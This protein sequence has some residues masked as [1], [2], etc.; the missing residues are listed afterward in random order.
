MDSSFNNLLKWLNAYK[1]KYYQNLLIKGSILSSALLLSIFLVFNSI[2]Y[3]LRL[4]G[5]LRGVLLFAFIAI[6]VAVIWQWVFTPISRLLNLKKQLSHEEAAI[7]IGKY[8]PQ[9]NDKLLNTIQLSHSNVKD[10]TL[11]QASI[12]QRT[13]ELSVFNFPKAINFKENNQYLKYLAPPVLVGIVILMLIPQLFT[14]GTERIINFNKE[15]VPEAPF[16]FDLENSDLRAFKNEDFN[17]NLGFKGSYEPNEAYIVIGGRK[18]KMPKEG[19]VYTYTFKN[20]QDDAA[21][22]FEAAGFQSADHSIKVLSRPNLKGFNVNLIYPSY[23][24]KDKK[25][26]ENTGNLIIPEG[27]EVQ[28]QFSSQDTEDMKLKFM[29]EDTIYKIKE[30]G[31]QLFSFNKTL[32]NSDEYQVQLSNENSNN[33]EEIKYSIDV[34][35]DQYPEIKVEIFADTTLYNFLVLGGSISDDYGFKALK[36]Y[37][38]IEGEAKSKYSAINLPVNNQQ[39]S[40]SFYF[41]W[42]TDSLLTEPGNRINYFLEVYDN[43]GVNGSKSTKS[44]SYTFKMPTVDEVADKL[45]KEALNTQERISESKNDVE[46][47]KKDLE[48]L[49]N[50]LKGKQNLEWQDKKKIEN[51][52]KRKQEINKAIEELKEK[53]KANNLQRER[54]NEQDESIREKS[55]QL[56]KLMNELLDEETKKLYDELK[57][58]LEEQ[59]DVNSIQEQ[60]SKINNKEQ[61][62]EKELERALELF[63]RMQFDQKLDN[64]VS[65]I[66]ELSKEQEKIAEET[67]EADKKDGSQHEEAKQKQEELN[68]KFEEIKKEID[69]LQEL[70]KDLEH[71]NPIQ[72]T[73][74]EEEKIEEEQQE[75][76]ESLE[77]GKNEKAAKHQE[78][79]AEEMKKLG[80][81]MAQMQ[82]GMEMSMMEENLD[83][84][85][86]ILDNLVKLSFNQEGLMDDFKQ[87]NQSDPRFVKLS[88]HQLKLKDDAKIIEDSLLSLA[89]RVFQIQSF[90]TREVESMNS[91]MEGSLE[92]LKERNPSKAI[93]SQQFAMTSMNNLALL[94]SDVLKQMQQQ[95]ADAMGK[96]QNGKGKG[97]PQSMDLGDLQKQL[98]DKISELKKS[99][100]SGRAMSEELAKLAAQQEQ[101]RRALQ[102]ELKKAENASGEE[103]KGGG[104]SGK[105]IIEKM[106]ETEADLVNKSLTEKTIKRQQD[107]LTRLLESEN[108]IREREEDQERKAEQANDYEQIIPKAFEDYLKAK[109]KEIE[110]LKTI[111]PRLNPYYIEE[112]NKYFKRLNNK[113]I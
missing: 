72:D 55:E 29:N 92:A 17:L 62:L 90:V 70:N 26:V 20:I 112:V 110:L 2:E 107:I 108:A 6:L 63:K 23:L 25:R 46:N 82:A 10:N 75:G 58:L 87:V 4:A 60:I 32:R 100:K 98:N 74:G 36:L 105:D 57:K 95:M 84:L 44:G 43:D 66:D 42:N 18:I 53:N 28:W 101:I 77:K 83:H 38:Q 61:N 30:S 80:E 86:D 111:P 67:K 51:I 64:L 97:K 93:S 12:A 27:T 69:Q 47:L 41:H 56:Q 94:L 81:K 21:F 8:F 33:K 1:K 45:E 59:K 35:K 16:E 40:Q 85:R 96:P 34:I 24:G 71:P 73:S 106:E 109:E 9:I 78:K 104:G 91:H 99:G 103:G 65:E 68:K 5:P 89:N 7:Q 50:K 102:E 88:Q 39:N 79:A 113:N 14:E 48:E 13:K 22:H 15:Y 19:N 37:Y 3:T 54:F 11:I 76:S 49:E 31:D 52:L